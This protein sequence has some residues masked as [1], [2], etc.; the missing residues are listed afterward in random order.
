MEWYY[1]YVL[2][3]LKDKMLYTGYSSDLKKRLNQH[4]QGAVFATKYRLPLKLIYSE[5]CLNKADAIAR[6]K[7]LKSGMGKRYLKTRLKHYYEN[8]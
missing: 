7:Y 2:Y 1:I 4:Q 5:A 8:L 6:E 3:S